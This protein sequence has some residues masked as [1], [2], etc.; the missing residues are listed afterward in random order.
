MRLAAADPMVAIV[1][2]V[3]RPTDAGMT[4]GDATDVVLGI[5]HEEVADKSARR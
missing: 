3:G 5:L 4:V 1:G 2:A